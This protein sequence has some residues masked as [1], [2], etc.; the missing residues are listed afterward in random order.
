MC[1]FYQQ[2]NIFYHWLNNSIKQTLRLWDFHFI[3]YYLHCTGLLISFPS[4]SNGQCATRWLSGWI[5][6]PHIGAE[7]LI[8]SS[9]MQYFFIH[10]YWGEKRLS[11]LGCVSRFICC[12]EQTIKWKWST[13]DR[14]NI[15][16][17]YA[18]G[19]QLVCASTQPQC[20][21][22]KQTLRSK[23]KRTDIYM[24]LRHGGEQQRW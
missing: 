23:W 11:Y 2:R 1:L 7:S 6:T 18:L 24:W 10:W 5:T 12:R 15:L 14:N 17:M 13:A 22:G 19:S 3:V 4:F 16:E 8:Y 20:P 21:N 9:F